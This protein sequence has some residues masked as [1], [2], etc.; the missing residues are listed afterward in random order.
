[1]TVTAVTVVPSAPLLVPDLAGGS[2]DR[3]QP[4]LAAC[5][6]GV[7]R[8]VSVDPAVILVLARDDSDRELDPTATW[9]FHGFGIARHP[10]PESVLPWRL[11]LG[12]W[13]L[14]QAGWTGARRYVGVA[15]GHTATDVDASSTAVLAMADGSACRTE[16]AP[17]HL[18][19]RASGFDESIEAALELGDVTA[20]AA[21]DPELARELM[22]SGVPVWQRLASLLDGR[23]VSSAELLH[24][25]ADYGVG[26]AVAFWLL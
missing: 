26:Y 16:K 21:L 5:L 12:A 14:D 9:D 7:H 17:G 18:D 11:G 10:T 2:A 3:D 1:M 6:D 19:P 15:D 4:L 24:S 22:C 23:P 13:L 20:L 8:L 25:C